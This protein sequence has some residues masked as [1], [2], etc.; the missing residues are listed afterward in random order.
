MYFADTNATHLQLSQTNNLIRFLI[1]LISFCAPLWMQY[2]KN[3]IINSSYLGNKTDF[4][5]VVVACCYFSSVNYTTHPYCIDVSTLV[6]ARIQLPGEIMIILICFRPNECKC[7]VLK[8][9][10]ETKNV[11]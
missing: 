8:G 6:V 7:S 11:P 10:G 4:N 5:F 1:I 2:L 9:E 3:C